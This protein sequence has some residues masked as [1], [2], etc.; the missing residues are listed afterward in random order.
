MSDDDLWRQKDQGER[1]DED[2][3]AAA[4][5]TSAPEAAPEQPDDLDLTQPI[6]GAT[7]PSADPYSP[8]PAAPT[9]PAPSYDAPPGPGAVPPPANPY[10][11]GQPGPYGAPYGG[12]Q[13]PPANPYGA[14][15]QP[16]FPGQGQGQPYQQPY[17]QPYGQQNPFQ[18]PPNPYPQPQE[19]ASPQSPYGVPYQPAYAG[20]MLPDHPSATTAMV[21]G[22]VGL[23]GL[24]FCGGLTL[25]LSPFAWA[26]GAKSVREI[27]AQ[28]GRYGGRDKAQ[29]GKWMGIIGTI[30]L[31]LGVALIIF[32]IAVGLAVDN[33]GSSDP[34]FG[35]G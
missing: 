8:P 33:G 28:P 18:P 23:V 19:Y 14:G 26:T 34:T 12:P 29:A 16:P 27:D 15:P 6:T 17:Q 13:Q 1:P 22:I 35:N 7:A 11:Q 31:I 32:L 3:D 30:L 10:G 4:D 21:L 9:P 5:Q 24:L 25:L 2:T 20:G